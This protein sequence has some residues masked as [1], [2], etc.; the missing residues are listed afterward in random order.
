MKRTVQ[1]SRIRSAGRKLLTLTMF[2]LACWPWAAQPAQNTGVAGVLR[3]GTIQNGDISES[4]GLVASRQYP[5]VL[6]THNDGGNQPVLYA[7]TQAGKS[8]GSYTIIGSAINDWESI[9]ADSG[10]NLYLA[11]IGD[12]NG[13]RKRVAVHRLRE[14]NP[15]S[16]GSALIEQTWRLEYPGSSMDAES[17][18]VAG[19]NGYILSKERKNEDR[20]SV[21]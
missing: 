7:I 18:F 14:P 10:G 1:L 16:S 3:T 20:K 6:W 2:G 5:G 19:G 11:D 12:N 8:L 13:K 4:S 15:G 17:F 21:V 9:A